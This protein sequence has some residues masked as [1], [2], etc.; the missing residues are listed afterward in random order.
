MTST[1]ELAYIENRLET[2]T[3]TRELVAPPSHWETR[4]RRDLST[5]DALLECIARALLVLAR[6]E[7]A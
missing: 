5:T 7:R 2:T 4:A 3:R 1:Q 6:G